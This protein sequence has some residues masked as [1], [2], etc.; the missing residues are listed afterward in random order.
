MIPSRHSFSK[1]AQQEGESISDFMAELRKLA[2]P[3][4]FSAATL[5]E[6]LRDAFVAGIS[7][8]STLDRIFEEDDADLDRVYKI[9]LA[10]EKAEISAQAMLHTQFKPPPVHAV[11]SS[12]KQGNTKPARTNQ[13]RRVKQFDNSSAGLQTLESEGEN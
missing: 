7:S 1:R 5:S 8:R 12:S 11:A 2:I 4:Q 9:A 3:C 10:I 6:R 13:N